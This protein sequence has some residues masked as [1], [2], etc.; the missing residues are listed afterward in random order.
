MTRLPDTQQAFVDWL[1]RGDSRIRSQISTSGKADIDTRLAIYANAYRLRLL[2]ALQDTFPALHTLLGDKRFRQ[3]GLDYLDDSPS[4]H[5]SIR[6]FG[7]R[8]AR[9]LQQSPAWR[10][11]PL[12][13]GHRP[14]CRACRARIAACAG[15]LAD[16]AQRPENILSFHGRRRSQSD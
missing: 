9:F 7:H 13:A 12:L 2:E 6:Y 15:Q 10:D 11:N 1:L 14:G 3:L 5:F 16:L 8:L 4:E